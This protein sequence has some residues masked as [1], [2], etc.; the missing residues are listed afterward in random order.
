M[1]T[2]VVHG[3]KEWPSR[4]L[5]LWPRVL[6]VDWHG[7]LSKA[8]LWYSIRSNV[9]HP[10]RARL[11]PKTAELFGQ[12]WQTVDD[13]MR[14]RHTAAEIVALLDIEQP[15][16]ARGDYFLRQL[17]HDCRTMPLHEP[18]IE[19]LRYAAVT[20]NIV[21]ATDNMDCLVSMA[22]QRRDIRRFSDDLISSS[23]V[24]VL[25]AED[26]AGFFGAWLESRGLTFA[27]AI[28]LDDGKAN[29]RAFEEAG[30]TS[31][32][33]RN[34]DEAVAAVWDLLANDR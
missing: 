27:N 32:Y 3:L 23:D 11:E 34:P 14:G 28:L 30:G 12:R 1:G 4:Q 16:S 2:R 24:G 33:V 17:Y 5:T 25:K 22:R 15:Q 13:W 29:C 6:F 21:I 26:P 8:P 9:R 19:A 31:R 10:F 7:V 20:W 18:L